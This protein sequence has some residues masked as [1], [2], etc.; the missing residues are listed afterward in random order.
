MPE[1]K[2]DAIFEKY[3]K[4]KSGEG[5]G[6]RLA[7]GDGCVVLGVGGSGRAAARCGSGF[8]TVKS[9]V[10]S[11]EG[12]ASLPPAGPWG[13]E[14]RD[15]GPCTCPPVGR[16]SGLPSALGP[17]APSPPTHPPTHSTHPSSHATHPP[18]PSPLPTHPPRHH[19]L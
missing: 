14:R 6:A 19:H 8:W 17:P 16:S 5:W 7:L 15:P 18:D 13:G 11:N 10:K 1:A 3:D 4:D 9:T 2:L 12:P